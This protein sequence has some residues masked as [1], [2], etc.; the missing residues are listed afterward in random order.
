[1]IEARNLI[2]LSNAQTPL[3]GGENTSLLEGT[4][5]DG[6][7]PR[8]GVVQTPNPLATPLRNTNGM[9]DNTPFKTPR[10]E[11]ASQVQKKRSLLQG[12][13]S[14]PKPRNEWE[15]K[16]PDMEDEREKENTSTDMM[17]DMSDYERE[18]KEAAEKEAKE[19]AARRSLAVQLGLP[20]PSAVPSFD[21]EEDA[22]EIEKMVHQELTRLLKH[23]AVKYPVAGS[24]VAPGVA[25][26]AADIADL[27]D[28]F[29]SVAL[30]DARKEL[31][32]EL[33]NTLGLSD[34]QDIKQQVWIRFSSAPNF[35][36]KWDQQHEDL[37]FSSKFKQFMKISE[38]DDDQDIVQ[39]L[40]R[41]V[42]VNIY[43]YIQFRS[44]FFITLSFLGKSSSND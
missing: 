7:T 13:S 12:L 19:R 25:T 18:L 22:T 40:E 24:K 36:E 2:A 39:D 9:D 4:G 32:A 29:D 41:T 5:F 3:L 10:E 11:K 30:R 33:V 21:L 35:E 44:T 37:L 23:D 28:E 14:L 43:I 20:R 38:M 42:E 15:I 27:E 1:M 31:D 17:E 16:L 34:Q 6:A 8:H 26:L